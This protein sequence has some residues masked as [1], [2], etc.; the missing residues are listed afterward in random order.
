MKNENCIYKDMCDL[1]CKQACMRYVEMNYMLK[2][3]NIPKSKQC[4][5]KLIPEPCD[6]SAFE[7]LADVRNSIVDF[8]KNGKQLYIYSSNCGN[9]K[10]TWAIKLMLQYFHESWAGNGFTQRGIFIHVP[11]YLY[12]C[13][14]VIN[15]PDESFELLRY[16]LPRVDLVIWD[17]IASTRLSEYDYTQLLVTIDQRNLNELSNIYTGNIKPY[18]LERCVGSKLASRMLGGCELVELKG[19]DRR[20]TVTDNK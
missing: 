11:T 5:N 2:H 19:G 6:E 1:E 16:M 18:D 20:G 12:K 14:E 3:S 13:K 17:E 4:I 7:Y 8:T 15:K 9:G 10:T